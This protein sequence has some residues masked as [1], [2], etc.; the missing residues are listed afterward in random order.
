[1]IRNT[2]MVGAKLLEPAKHLHR[3]ASVVESY[4]EHWDGSGYPKGLRGEQIPLESRI[5]G[6]VDAYVAM[7]SDRPHRVAMTPK[8]AAAVL[9]AGAGKE[10]DPR[11]VKLFLSVLHKEG[12]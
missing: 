3:V 12:K 11:L 5:I 4:H 10:W 7:T 6:L 9:Q 1:M 2:P 8:E